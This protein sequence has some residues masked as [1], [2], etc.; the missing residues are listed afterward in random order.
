ML[1]FLAF[2]ILQFPLILA[3][4]YVSTFLLAWV[5]PG[6]PFEKERKLAPETKKML[7]EKFHASSPG[8]FLTHYPWKIITTGD[9]GPSLN[10]QEFSVNDILRKS[11]PVS[12]TLGLAAVGIALIGGVFLGTIAAVR[13]NGVMDWSSLAIAL[14]GVSVPSFVGA[15]LLLSSFAFSKSLGLTIIAVAMAVAS[16]C[17]LVMQ[18][19]RGK[20]EGFRHCTVQ[21]AFAAVCLL[22]TGYLAVSMLNSTSGVR[23]KLEKS[24]IFPLGGWPSGM[25]HGLLPADTP[26]RQ[27]MFARAT[28][29]LKVALNDPAIY[30][31]PIVKRDRSSRINSYEVTNKANVEVPMGEDWDELMNHGPK[32]YELST[33][34]GLSF[35]RYL[36]HMTLPALALSL[37]PMA[38]ITRLTR[39][40]MIDVLA[41]DY[42]R[43]A[44]AKGLSRPAVIWRHCLRNAFLPVLS[45]IGP[46][47][48]ATLVGSFVV[49]K[50]FNIPGMGDYFVRSVLNRDQT[51]ILGTVMVYSVLLL[52]LNLFVD[53]MYS[54][55]DPRIKME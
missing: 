9:F 37:L 10:Y 46:A 25:E 51:L 5:A 48:A 15:S 4:I 16:L 20:L 39:V 42:V 50:V 44:R 1:R 24:E 19:Q 52:S 13:R 12:V 22:L 8:K 2:R 34:W 41:S 18:I 28:P 40:S 14:I 31:E 3:I 29:E 55:V 17:W 36:Q 21:L 30:F 43:T 53:V 6:S 45:Y 47:T 23:Q 33:R 27:A 49:E 38:Y 35:L 11:L 54:V 7:E 32:Y 26:E